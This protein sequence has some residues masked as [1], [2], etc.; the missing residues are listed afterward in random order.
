M[1]Q[2]QAPRSVRAGEAAVPPEM[3]PPAGEPHVTTRP[4][5]AGLKV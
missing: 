4:Q 3:S 1:A 2:T 5:Q